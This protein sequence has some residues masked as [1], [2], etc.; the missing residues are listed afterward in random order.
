MVNKSLIKYYLKYSIYSLAI[1]ILIIQVF[2]LFFEDEQINGEKF[3][4][5]NILKFTTKA[6]YCERKN[7][8]KYAE[9]LAKCFLAFISGCLISE[10]KFLRFG[11]L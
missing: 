9:Y 3:S 8:T 5:K 10:S 4:N 7:S 11:V 2:T 6:E 1:I